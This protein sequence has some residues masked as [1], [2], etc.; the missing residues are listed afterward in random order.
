MILR[1]AGLFW[2]LLSP[3]YGETQTTLGI[4]F[5]SADIQV[6][7][8]DDFQNPGMLYVDQGEALA[9]ERK[10]KSN[11][12]CLD[13][14]QDFS[15]VATEF[16]KRNPRTNQLLTLTSQIAE[17][18]NEHQ[19]AE[20]LGYETE[21]M[22]SLTAFVAFQSRGKPFAATLEHEALQRGR[23]YFYKRKGQLNLAC[24]HC[25]E[26]NSGKQLRGDIISEGVSTGYPVY[27]LEWQAL[28][29]LQRRFRACDIGV[30]AEPETIGG[31][32]YT[33][34]ELYLRSRAGQLSITAPGVRR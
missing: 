10:G 13:C 34:L 7:Q 8:R 21:H 33:E 28:G 11:K 29:S 15:G 24:V 2:L 6:M 4:E 23:D 12:A 14:H 5:Q 9:R 27:R 1:V 16:P 22:Q 31:Q 3:A 30:R 18:R 25:H 19:N 26:Y 20:P 32:V 17:C